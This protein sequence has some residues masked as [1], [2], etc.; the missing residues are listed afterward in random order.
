MKKSKKRISIGIKLAIGFA[1]VLILAVIVGI[2]GIY[3]LLN[4]ID[5]VDKGDDANRLVKYVLESRKNEKNF[6]IRACPNITFFVN[7]IL[8]I[9]TDWFL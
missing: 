6:I 4:V 1:I 2:F 3:S 9:K 5:R 7:K 8:F